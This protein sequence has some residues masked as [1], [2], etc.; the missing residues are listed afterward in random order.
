M[1]LLA[2]GGLAIAPSPA[3]A[4]GGAADDGTTLTVVLLLFG[5]ACAYLLAHF[6][7]DQLQARFLVLPGVEYLV[8]GLL[9]AAAVPSEVLDLTQLLPII[10]LA[11]GWTGL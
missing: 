11:A 8:L 7:V 4:S 1:A 2:L 9:L 5:V 3:F 6:V 10:A